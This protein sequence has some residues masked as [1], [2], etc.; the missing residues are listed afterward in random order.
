VKTLTV[1]RHAKSSGDDPN[2]NDFDRPLNERGRKSAR[3][4]GK[5]LKH[6]GVKFDRVF[7]SPAMRVRETLND[8]AD[9]YDQQ[10]DVRF[11]PEIYEATVERLLNLVRE[12]PDDVAEPLIVGHNPGLQEL[13]VELTGDDRDKLRHRIVAKFPAAAVATVRLPADRWSDIELGSGEIAELI[14][15][16][17]LD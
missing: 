12:L 11:A 4:M 3:A 6:R 9:G 13:L 5:E 14:L 16:K 7:A 15:P 2:L 1:M 10:L 8:F 17:E